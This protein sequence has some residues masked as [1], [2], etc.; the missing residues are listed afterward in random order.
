MP[1]SAG[2][3]VTTAPVGCC[4]S[5]VSGATER[6]NCT[7]TCASS[8]TSVSL[9]PGMICCTASFPVTVNLRVTAPGRPAS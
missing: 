5:V 2:S 3:N 4:A 7:K 1:W 8:G 6:L 9:S